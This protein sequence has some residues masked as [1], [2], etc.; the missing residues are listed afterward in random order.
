[1]AD[2]H[3][4]HDPV[5]GEVWT[6]FLAGRE[7][8]KVAMRLGS[9]LNLYVEEHGLGEVA[10]AET[11]FILARNPDTVLGPDIAFVGAER[12]PE[13]LVDP[14][15][16]PIAPDLA[17]EVVSPGDRPGEIATKVQAYLDAGVQL[18]WVLY[19]SRRQAIEHAPGAPPRT[20]QGDDLLDRGTVVPSFRCP[21][22]ALWG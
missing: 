22:T 2:D 13:G 4:R 3:L 11:G 5:R 19:P 18:V 9:R 17:V 21:L 20:L 1:M 12:I 16:W 7:Q 15:L 10:A 14:G 8:G 6:I